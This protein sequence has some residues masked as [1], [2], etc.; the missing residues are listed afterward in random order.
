MCFFS[1]VF[2][3]YSIRFIIKSRRSS[4]RSTAAVILSV[5]ILWIHYSHVVVV[6]AILTFTYDKYHTIFEHKRLLSFEKPNANVSSSQMKIFACNNRTQR[7]QPY[8]VL[9]V[10]NRAYFT[11]GPK[12]S[13]NHN[14]QHKHGNS[15]INAEYG[16]VFTNLKYT[17]AC[18]A[19]VIFSVGRHRINV[20]GKM[21]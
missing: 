6:E 11:N 7:A 20:L 18:M 21:T 1:V 10:S 17:Q 19:S 3:F 9:Y 8:M 16:L 12:S 5:S 13:N 4:S 2:R 14:K 15:V